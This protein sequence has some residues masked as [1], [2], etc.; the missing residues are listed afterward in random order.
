MEKEEATSGS[1]YIPAESE[2]EE[3]QQEGRLAEPL[4]LRHL[5]NRR[6]V[7]TSAEVYPDSEE[8]ER[9]QEEDRRMNTVEEPDWEWDNG[10]GGVT[11]RRSVTRAPPGIAARTRSRRDLC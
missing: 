1:E 3:E 6:G 11:A 2:E 4:E 7:D 8:E 9:Q 10:T 5:A